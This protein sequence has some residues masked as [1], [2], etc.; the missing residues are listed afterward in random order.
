MTPEP[1]LGAILSGLLDGELAPG[2]AA[3]ADA[4]LAGCPQCRGELAMVAA[5]RQWVRQLPDVDP[6]PGFL[7]ELGLRR[8]RIFSGPTARRWGAGAAAAAI[9]A[10]VGLVGAGPSE[11]QPVSP[12]LDR[13]VEAHMTGASLSG[14]PLRQLL[15]AGVPV[16]FRP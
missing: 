9:L 4:H 12:S 14:D 5:A 2:E 3:A 7:D 15:P 8:F 11:N 16:T 10:A 1:H 13:L 6:P